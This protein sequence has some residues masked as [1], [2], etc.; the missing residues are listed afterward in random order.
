[1]TVTNLIGNFLYTDNGDF[2]YFKILLSILVIIILKIALGALRKKKTNIVT[3][4]YTVPWLGSAIA[5]GVNPIEMIKQGYK[6]Y[7]EVFNVRVLGHDMIMMIGSEAQEAFY[8]APEEVFNAAK[9]YKFTVP[10]FGEGVVYDSPP[11]ALEEQR[12]M[13][14]NGLTIKRFKTYVAKIIKEVEN[15]LN[16]TWKDSGSIELLEAL[17]EITVLTST[18]CLHGD[19]VRDNLSAKF[20]SLYTDLDRALSAI[21]F[22]YPNA[23]L[24]AHR[25]RDA[26]RE[27]IRKLFADIIDKRRKNDEHP[28]DMLQTL[29]ESS[30][31]D[32]TPLTDNDVCGMMTALMLAGQHTSNVSSTWLGI[33]ILTN[34]EILARV[35]KELDEQWPKG[36][37]LD[38]QKL[39]NLTFLNNC[40]KETLR[41]RPPIILVMRKVLQDLQYK[42]KIIPK[43]AF[44]CVSPGVCH[45]LEEYFPKPEVFDPD[46]FSK[47]RQE[48][49]KHPY[50]Y[51]AFSASRHSCIGEKFAYVQIKT[52]WALFLRK[53]QLKLAM[54]KIEPDYTTLIVGPKPPVTVK[55]QKIKDE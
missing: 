18:R 51:I 31:D 42:D 26:A 14:S 9:A 45:M 25:R 19:E 55:Y 32:G 16:D 48:D 27:R 29:I 28:E 2:N 13:V 41:L 6:K 15:H 20:A 53:Y 10:V 52:I 50:S 44:A 40:L 39:N 54:D 7:G 3:L 38:Y 21:A 46:R 23:P 43:G 22:Y 37:E 36:T 4:P 33:Y 34:P 11:H 24:P 47:E 1:M 5:W 12:K 49:K 30:Y 35:I 8:S 17:N